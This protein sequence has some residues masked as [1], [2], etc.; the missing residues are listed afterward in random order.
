MRLVVALARFWG[1]ARASERRSETLGWRRA[2]RSYQPGALE[3]LGPDYEGR[4][5]TPPSPSA[6]GFR[7]SAGFGLST[8]FRLPR[9]TAKNA[10]FCEVARHRWLNACSS[11]RRFGVIIGKLNHSWRILRSGRVGVSVLL[12]QAH[13][14]EGFCVIPEELLVEDFS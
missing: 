14:F 7:F 2:T 9:K 11:D 4:P 13:G 3:G 10:P 6:S 12:R 1:R 8:G 5:R